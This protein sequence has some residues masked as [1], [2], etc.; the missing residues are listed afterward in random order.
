MKKKLL[1]TAVCVGV[2]VVSFFAAIGIS[3]GID[4][5][6]W[7]RKVNIETT[8][9]ERIARETTLDELITE[10]NT[11]TTEE[12][13][14][15]W[16]NDV[17]Y[18]DEDSS[19]T[20]LEVGKHYSVSI[21]E[22]RANNTSIYVEKIVEEET[23]TEP[24]QSRYVLYIDGEQII[25][26]EGIEAHC[27]II[28][29]DESIIGKE[30]CFYSVS[31]DQ[32]VNRFAIYTYDGETIADISEGISIPKKNGLKIKGDGVISIT[33]LMKLEQIGYYN[34]TREYKYVNGSFMAV[35]ATSTDELTDGSQENKYELLKKVEVVESYNNTKV[36]KKLKKGTKVQIDKIYTRNNDGTE[37]DTEYDIQYAHIVIDGE[38]IGWIELPS[39]YNKKGKKTKENYIF[40][41]ESI[42]NEIS[43]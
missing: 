34:V 17:N 14:P 16:M 26:S 28:D 41:N 19:D 5:I 33:R 6:S 24:I 9:A 20:E 15:E 31:D 37:S 29:I 22:D 13:S 25:V 18:I 30:I 32:V 23:G 8:M 7:E 38:E 11:V 4:R 1:W 36:I 2:F 21:I 35:N 42:P 3:S 39:L 43:K 40:T 10:E 12:T 27:R